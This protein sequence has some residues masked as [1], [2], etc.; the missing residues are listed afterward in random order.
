MSPQPV[1]RVL[2]FVESF[3]GGVF[4]IVR[5]L[6]NGLAH[7]GVEV[8]IAYS[9]RAE[10]PDNLEQQFERS[11]KLF[12]ITLGREISLRGDLRGVL[13]LLRLLRE[14]KPDVLHAHSS[15]AGF[16]GRL[17]GWLCRWSRKSPAVVYSPHGFA[18]LREDVS[19]SKR[20]VYLQ[21]ERIAYGFGGTLVGC[22]QGEVDVSKSKIGRG[23]VRLIE[24]AVNVDEIIP[25]TRA[26]S[27]VVNVVTLGRL[28]PQ[29]HPELFAQIAR[30]FRNDA[31]VKF[32]W[33]G[34]GEQRFVDVL[35]AEPNIRLTGWLD[36]NG[37]LR[38]LQ[39]GDI[40]LQ[41]SRWEGMPVAV[42]EAMVMGTAAVVTDVIGNRDVVAHGE[43]GFVGKSREELE[44]HLKTLIGDAALRARLGQA[45]R[46]IG[47]E[48][49]SMQRF[50]AE[51]QELYVDVAMADGNLKP[52]SLPRDQSSI[53]R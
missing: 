53:G 10:T 42:I 43:T 9:V 41:T 7:H 35:S 19:M 17:G 48:R 49:F 47:K 21:L 15:K 14:F 40:Y 31:R 25:H 38:E 16:I 51:W 46:R 22:S 34:G 23:R 20:S 26:Q 32:T 27:D 33:I 36:R 52:S 12:P 11:V 3:G 39:G 18:F 8:G 29:K 6:S 28:L 30:A 2:H 45:A 50:V 1:L 24:N 5:D 37:A 44:A 13:E 4:T